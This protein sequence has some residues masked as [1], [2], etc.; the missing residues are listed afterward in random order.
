MWVN[1]KEKSV[2]I[3]NTCIQHTEMKETCLQRQE[4]MEFKFIP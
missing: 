3:R 4:E 2:S 1:L